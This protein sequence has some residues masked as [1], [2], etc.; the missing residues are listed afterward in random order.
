MELL[1][2]SII[3]REFVNYRKMTMQD[4]RLRFSQKVRGAGI[5]NIPIVVDSV[6]AELSKALS[7]DGTNNVQRVGTRYG[8]EMIKHMDTTVQDVLKDVKSH[9]ILQDAEHVIRNDILVLGLEDGT[10]LDNKLDV[11][12]LYKRY[13]NDQDR[14]LYLM[15]TKETT[16]YGYI[17]SIL[18][19]LK[20]NIVGSW[21][22]KK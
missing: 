7:R 2:S 11:G 8:M 15:I 21:L 10:I 5:G 9:L 6:D 3:G 16:V 4:E 14:I 20:D 17:I 13:R 1:R 12:T 18:K 19:Y 22:A